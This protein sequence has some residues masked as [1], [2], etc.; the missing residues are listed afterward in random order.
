MALW[1]SEREETAPLEKTESEVSLV[2][3]SANSLRNTE[4]LPM[5]EMKND[6]LRVR[7][8]NPN[9]TSQFFNI[10]LVFAL[11]KAVCP[12]TQEE[13]KRQQLTQAALVT[14]DLNEHLVK[15]LKWKPMAQR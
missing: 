4:D 1:R 11:R 15:E 10:L 9:I 7:Q 3:C 8:E 14:R 2:P 6:F 5:Q 13:A 12:L